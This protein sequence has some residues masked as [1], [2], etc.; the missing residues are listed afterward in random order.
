MDITIHSIRSWK[1]SA[2][3]AER[4]QKD[5]IFL[6]GDSA[7]QFPPAGGFGMNTG[8]Q[9]AHNLAWKIGLVHNNICNKELLLSYHAGIPTYIVRNMIPVIL[10]SYL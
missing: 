1:M 9:D 7:H 2:V 4:F 6:V 10:I 8:I 5:N 3:V